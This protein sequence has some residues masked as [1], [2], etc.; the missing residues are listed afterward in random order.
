MPT[1]PDLDALRAEALAAVERYAVAA[2]EAEPPFVPGESER[3]RR[4]QG[5]RLARSCARSSTPRSTAGSPRAATRTSSARA[6]SG[7]PSARTSRSSARARRPTCSP[8]RPAARTCTSARSPPATRS[9]RPRSASPPPSRPLY[10]HGLRPVYVDVEPDTYNP[11]LEAFAAADR[12]AHARRSSPPTASATRSTRPG[13]E[14]LCR[15]HDLMLIEDCCDAL[16]SRIG[17]RRSARSAHAAT[18]SF[19]PAHHMTTGEGGAVATDGR[20]RGRAPSRRCASGAATAG[21]RPASTTSAAAASRAA[22]A[23]CRPATTTSTSSRTWATTSSSPTCR[24]RSVSP[25]RTAWKASR[26]AGGRTSTAC[27]PRFAA[28]RGAARAA[29]RA[30]RGRAATGSAIPITLREGGAAERRGL[31]L[32]LLEQRDRLAAP[33][34]RQHDAA[35]RFP[36]PR[37]PQSRARSRPPTGSRRP[38]SGWAATPASAL[39]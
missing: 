15:E 36:G 17:G 4:R 32:H 27:T 29:A 5:D 7:S 39:R 2:F 20:R 16:G 34:G 8:S 18:Y 38:R 25:R 19:Y 10:Q 31:Q 37:P 11:S 23:R 3:A 13:V 14:A 33:A 26:P 12:P 30:A 24:P 35:A 1:A 6:S 9:S 21:A 28:A 22:S